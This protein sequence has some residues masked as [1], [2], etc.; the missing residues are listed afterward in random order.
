MNK[1]DSLG[2][3]YR[4]IPMPSS[5]ELDTKS[6]ISNPVSSIPNGKKVFIKF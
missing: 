4:D 2:D 1:L 5:Y 3:P 6:I